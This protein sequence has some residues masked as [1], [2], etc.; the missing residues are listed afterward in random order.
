MKSS[1]QEFGR[2]NLNI[3]ECSLIDKNSVGKVG[4]SVNVVDYFF[5]KNH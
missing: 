3:I 1:T 5:Y 4:I 2:E